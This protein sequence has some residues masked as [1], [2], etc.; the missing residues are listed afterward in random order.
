MVVS[1]IFTKSLGLNLLF[2]QRWTLLLLFTF[3]LQAQDTIRPAVILKFTPSMLLDPDNT[4]TLG[5]EIPLSVRWSV[6]QEVGW[7]NAYM[8]L[9]DERSRY[10]EKNNWRFR[11]QLRY[12]F[13]KSNSKL[14]GSYFALE[15]F[16]KEVFI[17]QYQAIGRQCNPL[18]GTCAYFEEGILRT[19]RRVSALHGKFGYQWLIPDRMVVDI[20]IGGGFRNLIVT[21]DDPLGQA[22]INLIRTN[23]FNLRSLRPGK[24]E[25]IA[26]ISAG[27]SLGIL[28]VQ[29]KRK[30]LPLRS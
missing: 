15:Y 17:R 25:P 7:G 8:N 2:C 12:Y 16:R 22:N 23:F 21:N 6:Q 28:L 29:K 1:G 9:W 4:L 5:V 24:Y 3:S 11:T 26:S 20:Y 18:T 10:T 19:R 30:V 27:F 14:S 13:E